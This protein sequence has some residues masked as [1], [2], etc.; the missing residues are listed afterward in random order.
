MAEIDWTVLSGGLSGSQVRRGAT[1]AIDPPSGGDAFTYVMRSAEA[2]SGAVGFY[3]VITGFDPMTAGGRISMA[4]QRAAGAGALNY[5]PMVFLCLQGSAVTNEGY[6]LGFTSDEDPAHLVL[7]KGTP[8]AGIKTTSSY[9]LRQST[10][11]Y[12]VGEWYHFQLDVIVQPSGDVLLKV[13]END[14]DTYTVTSP[15]WAAISGM[16]DFLDDLA[17]HGSG[18]APYVSGR[19]GYAGY[20]GGESGRPAFFDHAVVGR[21]L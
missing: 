18:T 9:I 6:L 1:Q 3:C 10:N 2:V 5:C 16:T 13:R 21:Q 20:F 17:G 11:T 7:M 12:E 8:A 4:L 19:G 14:L 15:T